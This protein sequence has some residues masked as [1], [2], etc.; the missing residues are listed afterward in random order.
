MIPVLLHRGA[1]AALKYG[2]NRSGKRFFAAGGTATVQGWDLLE[3]LDRD[4]LALNAS[5]GGQCRFVSSYPLPRFY[6]QLASS[7]N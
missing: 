5:P 3:R 2:A 1:C 7:E 6:G 4:L